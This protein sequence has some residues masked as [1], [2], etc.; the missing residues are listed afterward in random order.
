M[1]KTFTSI[2]FLVTTFA[3]ATI[4]QTPSTTFATQE[5][6]WTSKLATNVV[7][8]DG[9]SVRPLGIQGNGGAAEFGGTLNVVGALST[10]NPFTISYASSLTGFTFTR[11]TVGTSTW[12]WAGGNLNWT[13]SSGNFRLLYPGAVLSLRASTT[14]STTK[15]MVIS[16]PGY[17]TAIGEVGVLQWVNG[18]SENI[19]VLGSSQTS[20]NKPQRIIGAVASSNT[21]TNSVLQTFQITSQGIR[22]DGTGAGGGPT[23]T[24]GTGSPETVVTAPVGSVYLRTD[25]GA[26]TTFYVKEVGSG[27]TGWVGK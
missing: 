2:L 4:G 25:G 16:S 18:V 5:A 7:A 23:I 14:T 3:V 26:G 13:L 10:S 12:D 27:N 1:K 22:V 19:L 20:L 11:P 9:S 21:A 6:S 15:N 8:G 17:D 24:S